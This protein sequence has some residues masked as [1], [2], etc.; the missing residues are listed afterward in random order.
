MRN[1]VVAIRIKYTGYG[2][3]LLKTYQILYM[4]SWCDNPV[5]AVA[6]HAIA[7]LVSDNNAAASPLFTALH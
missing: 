4:F 2:I 1:R 7:V 5:E 6:V 3:A